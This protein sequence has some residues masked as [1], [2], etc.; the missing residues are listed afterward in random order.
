MKIVPVIISGGVGSRL[1]P[2]SRAL[3]PKPFILLPEGTLIRKTYARAVEI[4]GVDH[5]VT[6]T[7]RDLLFLTADEYAEVAAP[8][9]K[10]TF[11]LEP[12]I[13]D[14]AA[15]IALAALHVIESI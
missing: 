14:T 9:V 5:V 15:A 11:L 7:N 10:N 4:E 3:H 13:R 8:G 12:F 2:I 1:W 6:V